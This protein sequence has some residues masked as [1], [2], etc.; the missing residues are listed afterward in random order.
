MLALIGHGEDGDLLMGSERDHGWLSFVVHA[1]SLVFEFEV[2][3]Y[4]RLVLL[5]LVSMPTALQFEIVSLL[6]LASELEFELLI[7]LMNLAYEDV[8]AA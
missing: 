6:A 2:I 1:R 4:S 3:R 7:L 5:M 8:A